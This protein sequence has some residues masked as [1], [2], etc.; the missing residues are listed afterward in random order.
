[1]PCPSTEE[2]LDVSNG[3]GTLPCK[4]AELMAVSAL[5]GRVPFTIVALSSLHHFLVLII[6]SFFQY[7]FISLVFLLDLIFLCFF[8]IG[9][10][11]EEEVSLE[12]SAATEQDIWVLKGIYP[13]DVGLIR[14]L[15]AAR[16][17][18]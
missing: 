13:R 5:Q 8:I 3:I 18:S 2:T 7:I 6:R 10:I 17:V 4:V 14:S 16:S 12:E 9:F 15:D 11:L 1:M